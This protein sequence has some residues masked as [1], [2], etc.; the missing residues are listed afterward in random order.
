MQAIAQVS[1]RCAQASALLTWL[2][3]AAS[4]KD[5]GSHFHRL[6][7]YGCLMVLQEEMAQ[8]V[9]LPLKASNSQSQIRWLDAVAATVVELVPG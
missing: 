8:E 4:G 7:R 5:L 3:A 9:A 6:H 1:E 2:G